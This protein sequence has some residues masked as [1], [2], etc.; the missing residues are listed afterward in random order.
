LADAAVKLLLDDALW[1]EASRLQLEYG[2]AH[3]SRAA[4]RRTF[5][6]AIG[7]QDALATQ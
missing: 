5:L 6:E 3:F 1:R 7:D 2:R 4:F